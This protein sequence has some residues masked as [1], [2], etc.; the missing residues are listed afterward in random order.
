[1]FWMF[2]LTIGIFLSIGFLAK[3]PDMFAGWKYTKEEA[4]LEFEEKRLQVKL[5]EKCLQ[6]KWYCDP[7]NYALDLRAT[8]PQNAKTPAD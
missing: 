3:G 7:H 5:K 2:V 6:D 4:K 1:M 8:E